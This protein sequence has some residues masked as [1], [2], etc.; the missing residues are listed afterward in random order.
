MEEYIRQVIAQL[1]GFQ[2]FLAILATIS[3][4]F[5]KAGI[6]GIDILTVTLMALVFGG[7]ASTGILLILLS[8]ADILAVIYY[9]RHVDWK[10][11][12]VFLPWI[13][14]GVLMG[15]YIGKDIDEALFKKIISGIILMAIVLMVWL[16]NRKT[17]TI[18]T[19]KWF[20]IALGLAAGITTMLGNLAGAFATV[21]FLVKRFPKNEFIGTVSWIFLVVNLFKI[22]FQ[23]FFWENINSHTLGIDLLLLPSVV[24]SFFI[25]TRIVRSISNEK[26]RKLVVALTIIGAFV[27]LLK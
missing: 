21:Y 7:K 20:A 25:G 17:D 4:G 1:T 26:Y 6:R 15:V 10:Q 14:V 8:S 22:P 9:K 23:L 2:W 27:I 18:P 3:L 12:R 11:F 13:L 16:E 24:L 5:S 19:N